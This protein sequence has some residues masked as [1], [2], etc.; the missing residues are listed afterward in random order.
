MFEKNLS[1]FKAYDIR[2][3]ASNL[4]PDIRFRL[5]NSVLSYFKNEYGVSELVLAHDARL[6]G[7]ELMEDFISIAG[8][9]GV[10]LLVNP[11]PVSTC[12]F[13]YSAMRHKEAAAVM[14]TAS[15]NPGNYI[16]LKCMAPSLEPIAEACGRKGGLDEI[17][18]LYRYSE[19]PKTGCPSKVTVFDYLSDYVNYSCS[20]A[21]LGPGALSGLRILANFVSGAAGMEVLS[22]LSHLGADVTPL[23]L[24]PDGLFGKG[25][26]NPI[27][28]VRIAEMREALRLGSY[29]IGFCYDGDGDRLDV[30]MPEGEQ[31]SPALNLSLIAPEIRQLFE[32]Y[33]GSEDYHPQLY[34]CV[35]ATP[36]AKEFQRNAGFR[37]HSIRNGHSYIKNSLRRNFMKQYL[38]AVEE[39]AHYY[40]SFPYEPADFSKGFA[41]VENTL[42]FTLITAKRRL[43]TPLKFDE[44]M[45]AQKS[46]ARIREWPCEFRDPEKMKMALDDVEREAGSNGYSITK[47]TED[48]ESLDATL[49]FRGL[50]SSEWVQIVSRI[51]RSEDGMIRFEICASDSQ[52]AETANEMIVSTLKRYADSGDAVFFEE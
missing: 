38:A 36:L 50:P 10:R 2:T 17:G 9:Y 15:H 23:N 8:E 46:F 44:A 27:V 49:Y 32:G 40:M 14:I 37:V 5:V 4:T 51:S 25:D 39:S 12:Q 48:G 3:V 11:L 7:P 22:A 33:F 18:K 43:E 24:V 1:M 35:K 20:L 28:K 34:T 6:A 42:Y 31:L 30:W 29:D 19:F 47:N 52:L 16:G 13:Y 26:P 21:G 41:A 45:K